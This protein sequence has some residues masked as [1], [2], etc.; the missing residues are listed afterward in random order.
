MDR[1]SKRHLQAG[2]E[3]T[4]EAARERAAFNDKRNAELISL[5]SLISDSTF[6]IRTD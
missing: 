5:K 3:Q 1:V 6:L 2:I 4:I